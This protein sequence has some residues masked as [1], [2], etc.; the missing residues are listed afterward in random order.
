M[1]LFR[2]RQELTPPPEQ[3]AWGSSLYRDALNFEKG[4]GLNQICAS[5]VHRAHD[6]RRVP[7]PPRTECRAPA[8]SIPAAAGQWPMPDV[9]HSYWGCSSSILRMKHSC[10]PIDVRTGLWAQLHCWNVRCLVSPALVC[11][12]NP[13]ASRYHS[14]KAAGQW[15]DAQ[16]LRLHHSRSNASNRQFHTV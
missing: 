2:T 16:K 11:L 3:R 6:L 1:H 15:P 10:E 5:S 7:H 14:Y 9:G 13:F 8:S 4:V 12:V